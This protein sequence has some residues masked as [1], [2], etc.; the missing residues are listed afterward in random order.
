[1]LSIQFLAWIL[2]LI[3]VYAV[4]WWSIENLKSIVQIVHS[5]LV[6]YFQPH[7]DL[8]LSER[9]GNWAGKL[10]LIVSFFL[11]SFCFSI[12]K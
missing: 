6:P 10:Y 1:M 5:L 9:F 7:E 2:I 4:L 3:G 11:L 12:E 8:K